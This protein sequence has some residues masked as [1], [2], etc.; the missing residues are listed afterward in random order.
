ML[1]ATAAN[2]FQSFALTGSNRSKEGA[3]ERKKKRSHDLKVLTC[4]FHIGKYLVRP[5]ISVFPA[6]YSGI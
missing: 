3:K 5:S 2:I 4:Q 1:L 6:E